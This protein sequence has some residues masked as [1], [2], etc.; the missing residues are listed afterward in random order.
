M[1]MGVDAIIQ[2]ILSGEYPKDILPNSALSFTNEQQAQYFSN[3]RRNI[4]S[5]MAHA[6]ITNSQSIQDLKLLKEIKG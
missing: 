4:Q 1:K 3:L 2:E 6:V 5:D